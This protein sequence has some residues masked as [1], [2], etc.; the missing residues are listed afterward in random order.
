[1]AS[2]LFRI[3][4]RLTRLTKKVETSVLSK[5]SQCVSDRS[6]QRMLLAEDLPRPGEHIVEHRPRGRVVPA[7][8]H[9]VSEVHGCARRVRVVLSE[10][11]PPLSEHIIKCRPRGWV[12]P[13]IPLGDREFVRGGDWRGPAPVDSAGRHCAS[14]FD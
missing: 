3:A 9:R 14:F 6:S 4:E 1:M 13:L 5:I 7:Y 8:P 10:Q 11:C 12:V 2:R